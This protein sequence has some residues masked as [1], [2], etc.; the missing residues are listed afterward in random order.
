MKWDESYVR[1]GALESLRSPC[2]RP[3]KKLQIDCEALQD[4][5]ILYAIYLAY[6]CRWL[7]LCSYSVCFCAFV[8]PDNGLFDDEFCLF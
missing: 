3:P 6:F 1:E 2:H 8:C 4:H 5:L 7:V